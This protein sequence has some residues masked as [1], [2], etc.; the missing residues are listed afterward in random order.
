[1]DRDVELIRWAP[2]ER[3]HRVRAG[4]K[5][6]RILNMP[7]RQPRSVAA[8]SFVLPVIVLSHARSSLNH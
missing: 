4:T 1:M 2:Q 3:P 5:K 6:S 8:I 7:R